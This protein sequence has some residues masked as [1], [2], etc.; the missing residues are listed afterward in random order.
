MTERKEVVKKDGRVLKP[1]K[2]KVL[3]IATVDLRKIALTS[4]H[5]HRDLPNI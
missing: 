2:R 4:E 3:S 1:V 5:C